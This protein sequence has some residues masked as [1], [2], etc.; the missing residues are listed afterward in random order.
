M[1]FIEETG[2]AQ[3]WRDARITT[4]Y[5]GTTAIQANDLIFRKLAR[6][7]GATARSV[8]A[9]I[10]ETI[11]ALR[12]SSRPDLQAI[13][14]RLQQALDDW[15]EATAWALARIKEDTAGVLTAAV[16]YRHLAATVCGGG[17]LGRAALTAAR[18]LEDASGDA[19]FLQ[20]KV[21]TARFYADHVLV[22]ASSLNQTVLAGGDALAALGDDMIGA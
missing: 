10:G 4:I 1:G 22:Q 6:D 8:F 16:P 12:S 17:Q 14:N 18:R 21:A 7:G 15:M 19:L 5:E 2:A 11:E 13:A 3:H 9:Q 20:A